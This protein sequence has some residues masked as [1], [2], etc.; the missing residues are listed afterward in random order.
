MAAEVF[1]RDHAAARLEATRIGVHYGTALVGNFGGRDRL[2][3]TA[4]RPVM[5]IGAR[6][7]QANKALGTR[8]CVSA[9]TLAVAGDSAAGWLP[10]GTLALRGVA[11]PLAVATPAPAALDRGAYAAALAL[12]PAN[13]PA[14]LAA[15]IKLGSDHPVVQLHIARLQQGLASAVIDLS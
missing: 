10:V 3:Y 14:A 12:I 15:L 7:E 1:R 13:P 9:A 2:D 6:L 4:H 5:N 11:D 8:V